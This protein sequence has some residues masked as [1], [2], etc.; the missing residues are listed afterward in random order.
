MATDSAQ[1]LNAYA[2]DLKLGAQYIPDKVSLAKERGEQVKFIKNCQCPCC[3]YWLFTDGTRIYHYDPKAY[4]D[5]RNNHDY[6]CPHC[7]NTNIAGQTIPANAKK[8]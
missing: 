4:L 7:G 3:W 2:E 5:L 6:C 1:P 8:K